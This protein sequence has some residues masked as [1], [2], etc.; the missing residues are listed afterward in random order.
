M[1]G[2][3]L[4][5]VSWESFSKN[6]ASFDK[7]KTSS[8]KTKSEVPGLSMRAVLPIRWAYS[9]TESGMSSNIVFFTSKKSRPLAATSV[10]IKTASIFIV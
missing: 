9:V 6:L 8:N 1:K 10:Q 3:Y 7:E 4:K 2:F 5:M